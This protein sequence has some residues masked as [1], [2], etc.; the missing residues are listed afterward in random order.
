MIAKDVKCPACGTVNKGVYLEETKGWFE[1][2]GCKL[3]VLAREYNHTFTPVPFL[4]IKVV[5]VPKGS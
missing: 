3:V 1:C 5:D 4:N 2:E